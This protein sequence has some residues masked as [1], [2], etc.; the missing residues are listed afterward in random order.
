MNK[1]FYFGSIF[2]ILA[3]MLMF[4]N[5]F[6]YADYQGRMTACFDAYYLDDKEYVDDDLVIKK[7]DKFILEY[8]TYLYPGFDDYLSIRRDNKIYEPKSEINLATFHFNITP[9]AEVDYYYDKELKTKAGRLDHNNIYDIFYIYNLK[10][11]WS[12]SFKCNQDILLLVLD[13]NFYYMEN[14]DDKE[15]LYKEITSE[16]ISN[17]DNYDNNINNNS[18]NVEDNSSIEEQSDN[19]EEISDVI[20]SDSINHLETSDGSFSYYVWLSIFIVACVCIII[21]LIT[22]LV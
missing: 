14:D 2:T 11:K 10:D 6:C 1:L 8:P 7:F 3:L 22:K 21:L 20:S 12:A 18:F 9:I 17:T 19:K 15:I 4:I 5:S 13:G 16:M